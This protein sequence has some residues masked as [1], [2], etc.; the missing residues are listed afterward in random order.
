MD[1]KKYFKSLVTKPHTIIVGG[2]AEPFSNK[3]HDE[4]LTFASD[5]NEFIDHYSRTVFETDS[6]RDIEFPELGIS[7]EEQD[8]IELGYFHEQFFGFLESFSLMTNCTEAEVIKALGGDY[9]ELLDQRAYGTLVD[10]DLILML[11]DIERELNAY[12]AARMSG[13]RST[14][15]KISKYMDILNSKSPYPTPNQPS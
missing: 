12:T 3:L 4:Y 2:K 1:Y 6:V 13:K 15:T 5:L 10:Q 14:H 7:A 8:Q 9:D 11:T